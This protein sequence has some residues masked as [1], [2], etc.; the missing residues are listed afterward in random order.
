[1]REKC[2]EFIYGMVVVWWYKLKNYI[3]KIDIM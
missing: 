2:E 3:E 1:M